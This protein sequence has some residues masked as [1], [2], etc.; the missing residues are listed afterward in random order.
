MALASSM[1][2]E[3]QRYVGKGSPATRSCPCTICCF[4]KPFQAGLQKSSR[5]RWTAGQVKA[6]IAKLDHWTDKPETKAVVDNLIRNTLWTQLPS[7]YDDISQYRQR[8]YDMC[9]R[10]ILTWRDSEARGKGEARWRNMK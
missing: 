2:Q 1:D 6:Q 7:C 4:Q 10:G 3:Q 9:I 8:I 5:W